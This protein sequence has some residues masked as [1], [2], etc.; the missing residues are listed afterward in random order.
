MT[1]LDILKRKIQLKQQAIDVIKEEIIDLKLNQ[2][3]IIKKRRLEKQINKG[4][5]SVLSRKLDCINYLIEN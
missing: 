1:D 3:I 4:F 5:D 2:A